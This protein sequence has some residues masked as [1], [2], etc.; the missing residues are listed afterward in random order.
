MEKKS[1]ILGCFFI[2][3]FAI[4]TAICITLFS[5]S[6]ES[7]E[8]RRKLDTIREQLARA[9]DTNRQ[10]EER[11]ER[12]RFILSDLDE[13]T[14][15]NITTIRDCVEIV[16]ETRYAVESLLCY[17]GDFDSNEYYDWLDNWLQNEGV[18]VV[19]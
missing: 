5:T 13:L 19:K 15:R 12:C 18:E 2:F 14:S 1:F 9:E 3:F 10:L 6:R 11:I 4:F 16:E 7:Y 8:T 17:L